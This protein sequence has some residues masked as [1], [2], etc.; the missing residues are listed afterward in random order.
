MAGRGLS[1]T[2]F[3]GCEH[4]GRLAH[5]YNCTNVQIGVTNQAALIG[6]TAR[7]GSDAA[8]AVRLTVLA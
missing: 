6:R 2:P 3:S 7:A 5:V 4:F 8:I 1:L